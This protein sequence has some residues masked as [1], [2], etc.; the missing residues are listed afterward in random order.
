MP[1]HTPAVWKLHIPPRV[2][3]FLWLLSK[4]KLLT[5]DNLAKR[6]KLEDNTCLFCAE[7]ETVHH[8]FFGCVVAQQIWV[9][10]AEIDGTD[11]FRDFESVARFWISD[12]KH[13][14]MN[15]FCAA[16]MWAIWKLRNS[17]CFQNYRWKDLSQLWWSMSGMLKNWSLLCPAKH[18][19][20]YNAWLS[21][22]EALVA[23]PGRICWKD[24]A[25]SW[26]T[27]SCKTGKRQRKT[28]AGFPSY[29]CCV[30]LESDGFSRGE[31]SW[32][33]SM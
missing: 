13:C 2:H 10:L 22:L 30:Q 28:V 16:A 23:M 26:S 18:L 19:E 24:G 5:R 11:G 25:S 32:G 4:N 20:R 27:P 17:L 1:V 29:S 15:M 9:G 12:K 7:T 21:S 8:L 33:F 14:V 31:L 3:I 6:R